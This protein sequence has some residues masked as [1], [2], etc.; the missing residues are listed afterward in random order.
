MFKNATIIRTSW[1]YSEYGNN[2]VKTMLRLGQQ[3]KEV[4]VVSDQRGSPTYA[5][6]LANVILK[7]IDI[8]IYE[9]NEYVTEH[10]PFF[11]QR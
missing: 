4:N 10:L 3:T 2:F 5:T 8:K 7:L 11:K 6:D 9:S 1:L